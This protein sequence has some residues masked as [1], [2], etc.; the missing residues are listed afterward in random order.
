MSA[1]KAY[2]F[3]YIAGGTEERGKEDPIDYR[4]ICEIPKDQKALRT[5][6]VKEMFSWDRWIPLWMKKTV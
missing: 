3:S 5:R 2:A 6:W 1:L 4:K